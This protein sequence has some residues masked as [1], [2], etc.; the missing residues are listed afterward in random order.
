M[1]RSTYDYIV[2]GAGSAGAVL[3]ARLSEDGRF[4]VLLLEAGPRGRSPWVHLP[5]GYGRTMFHPVLN[6]R[7]STEP[8]PELAGRRVYWPRGRCLGGSSAINGL[9]YIRGQPADY[10][11][12][13]ALGNSGWGWREVLPFFLRAESNDRGA[14]AWHGASGPL[15]VSDIGEAHPLMDAVIAAAGRL[16]VPHNPDFNGAVQEGVGY[17]QLTTRN[18]LRCSTATAYLRPARRRPNLRVEVDALAV[19]VLFDGRRAAG[20]EYRTGLRSHRALAAR[21]V[22]LA[23]GAVKSPQLLELSGVGDASRLRQLG[24]PLVH[25]LPGVGENLQDHLQL[26]VLYRVSVP[27][28]TNDA[29]RTWRGR[30]RIGL[31]WLLHRR[32][33][34]AVGINQGGL[35][36]RV[37]PE[38]TTPDVQFHFATLSADLAGARPHPWSGC[39]FS[40]CQLRPESR[41]SIH[42]RD[43]DPWTAPLIRANYLSHETDRRAAVAALRFT[44]RLAAAAPLSPFLAAEYRPGTAAASDE[45]LLQFARTHGA[46]IFH[47]VGTCRMGSDALAVVDHRLRVHGVAGLRV[48]VA[49]VMPTLVSGNT[50]APTVMIAEK[51][52]AMILE[53]ARGLAGRHADSCAATEI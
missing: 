13:A 24:I 21:E 41:G 43:A 20:V 38:S 42:I 29:L 15:A 7:F 33:P 16:G 11:H 18:G 34:L 12:W 26:R 51:A 53:D 27:F 9:I 25:H 2:V 3:A 6:W 28:T 37:L 44:R 5:I 19:R 36:T 49:S 22:V 39:T 47:P 17:F 14:D 8:E 52:A 40:V 32:G 35:F 1:H 46:T 48:V 50:H 30:A 23:A 4:R 31:E 10:D 45:D